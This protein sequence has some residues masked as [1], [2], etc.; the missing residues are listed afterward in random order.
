[1]KRCMLVGVAMIGVTLASV[2]GEEDGPSVAAPGPA[3][4]PPRREIRPGG[5][6]VFVHNTEAGPDRTFLAVGEGLT[7]DV[8]VWGPS[9]TD[10]RGRE[11]HAKVQFCN[12][13]YLAATIPEWAHD[14]VLLA[15]VKSDK[16]WSRPIV[17]NAPQA[18]WAFPDR[19]RPGETVTIYGRNLAR[20]PDFD[21][22]HVYLRGAKAG[23]GRW[24]TVAAAGKYRVR[25]ELPADLAPGEYKLWCHTGRGGAYGWSQPVRV[26]VVPP[27]P[28]PTEFTPKANTQSALLS[29]I[30][31]A[32]KAGGGVVRLPAGAIELDRT[33]KVP[34]GVVIVGT[35]RRRSTLRF[36]TTEPGAYAVGSP[37]TGWGHNP[38]EFHSPGDVIEYTLDVP[39]T[40]EWTVWLYYRCNTPRAQKAGISGHMTLS[41]GGETVSLENLPHTSWSRIGWARSARLKLTKGPQKLTWTNVNGAVVNLHAFVF[42]L[43]PDFT[44]SAAPYPETGPGVMVLQAGD[45]T[46]MVSKVGWLEG[47]YRAAVLLGGDGAGVRDLGIEGSG[48]TDTGVL[49]RD[50]K[51]PRWAE[52]CT[53]ENV[54]V[55]GIESKHGK[56]YAVLMRRASR[57][58]L[59]RNELWGRCPLFLSGVR[60]C[61]IRD[62]RLVSQRRVG[63]GASGAIEA[64]HDI[65]EQCIIENNTFA[66]APGRDAGAAGAQRMIWIS[67]GRGSISG[68]YIA[69]NAP[70]RARFM[71]PPGFG[72]NT[73]ETILFESCQR[74]VYFGAPAAADA[75]SVTLPRA[76]P[77]TP[78]GRLGSVARGSLPTDA[79]GNETPFLPPSPADCDGVSE[80]PADQY[81]VVVLDG[82]GMG[83]TRRVARREGHKLLLVRPWRVAPDTGSRIVVTTLYY[84]NLIVDNDVRDGMSGIQL[85]YTCVENVVAANRIRDH[86]R[87]G[88]SLWA[89][90]STLA[91]SMPMAFNRGL[92]PCH[93][94]V[95]EGNRVQNCHTGG[96]IRGQG[97][98]RLRPP[99]GFPLCIGNVMR[100]NSF[101]DNRGNGLSIHSGGGRGPRVADRSP[102]VVGTIVEFN[103]VRNSPG[104]AFHVGTGTDFAVLR[105]N[106][107]FFWQLPPAEADGKHVVVRLDA[108]GT[109]VTEL[110][111]AERSHS[112]E[113]EIVPELRP[114][115]QEQTGK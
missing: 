17:L 14:G 22:A 66:D 70:D 86:R 85:W 111:S 69:R 110:N 13:R 40:G 82:K 58:K 30:A 90:R 9:G 12:G 63:W 102:G 101:F 80:G 10:P 1:M 78:D 88:L 37:R 109:C 33:L 93:F 103:M 52:G 95:Y 83:Q 73:G 105:R 48:T 47:T 29:A 81:Y 16:G 31:E 21:R 49:V 44:P 79:E 50:E 67:T 115:Q 108:P 98:S 96:Y 75:R 7:S 64:R 32:A 61:D 59:L 45:A 36:A 26:R 20:R 92:T 55:T 42:A 76:F 72:Q 34:A 84:R 77:P 23:T 39:R 43:D 106:Q 53:V 54:R 51:F 41:A 27:K 5:P 71:P 15:W 18:W 25:V 2:R 11:Y 38:K 94:N 8:V 35:G 91:S 6:T 3:F 62:N 24:L 97:P 57:A 89:T 4:S 87:Q 46:R 99:A 56:S 104:P 28:K 65:V 60:Q 107:V 113:G 19:A 74:Y 100:H 112:G 68:N 114:Y